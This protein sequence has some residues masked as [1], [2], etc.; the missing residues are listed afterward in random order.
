MD[1]RRP[2]RKVTRHIVEGPAASR[3]PASVE[4]SRHVTHSNSVQRAKQP[5]SAPQR[6]HETDPEPVESSASALKA[7]HGGIVAANQSQKTHKKHHPIHDAQAARGAKSTFDAHRHLGH[8]SKNKTRS[9]PYRKRRWYI[10]LFHHIFAINKH[11]LSLRRRMYVRLQSLL[12][13]GCLAWLGYHAAMMVSAGPQPGESM[14]ASPHVNVSPAN[15]TRYPEL[16]PGVANAISSVVAVLRKVG[17][18]SQALTA[19]G[20]VLS[21][22]QVLTAGHEVDG[23]NGVLACRR[24]EAQASGLL[25]PAA[26]SSNVVSKAALK[27]ANTIDLAVLEVESDAN[28]QSLPTATLADSAPAAGS[29]VY[30]VNYQPKADGQTRSPLMRGASDPVIFTGIALGTDSHGFA[31]ATGQGKSYGLGEPETLL[32]KGASGGAV[33]DAKGNLLGLSVASDSLEADKTAE[34]LQRKFGVLLESGK[35]QVAYMQTLSVDT[36]NDMRSRL[37]LCQ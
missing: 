4:R 30:F 25:T 7:A 21:E 31:I 29:T 33:F 32:R 15:T 5:A 20:V 34:A 27:H 28:F 24:T 3:K 16:P 1:Q 10:R 19:S 9:W 18:G 37:E 22:N 26:A 11:H 8:V 6:H 35:Y 12:I 36:L 23:G 14:A 17:S 2:S 13:I